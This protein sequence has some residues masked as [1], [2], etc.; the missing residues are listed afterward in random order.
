MSEP[1]ILFVDD[2]PNI[3]KTLQ[4]IFFDEEY[5]IITANSGSDALALLEKGETPA[6]IV[7]DQRMPGMSGSEFLAKTRVIL[8][9]S[10]RIILTG[11]ADISAAVD[12]INLGGVFRYI[13]KP[14]DDE[15]LKLVVKDAFD[16]HRLVDEN[17]RL[18]QEIKEA[19]QKLEEINRGLEQ[20]VIERTLELQKAYEKNLALTKVL[21]KKVVELEGWDRIQRH[22]LTIHPIEE[23]LETFLEVALNVAGAN[24]AGFYLTDDEKE[25]EL[26][27]AGIKLTGAGAVD[28]AE[29]IASDAAATL[30]D[31]LRSEVLADGAARLLSDEQLAEIGTGLKSLA[32]IP[33][34]KGERHYGLIEVGILS[35]GESIDSG[36]L[37]TLFNFGMQAAIAI[38]DSRM[39]SILPDLEAS[40]DELLC[41]LHKD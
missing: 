17:N 14:W 23:T 32:L 25:Q 34:S 33:V 11:Y 21:K 26:H 28:C 16:R 19:N 40:L 30:L 15:D 18:N 9:E 27:P 12:A 36:K 5:R 31:P 10:I 1:T 8:P 37:H 22:I 41:S 6:V 29:K 2:E 7:S 35:G 4:R 20:K 24:Y 13:L 38:Q 39:D 3:L